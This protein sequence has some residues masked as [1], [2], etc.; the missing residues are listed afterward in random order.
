VAADFRALMIILDGLRSRSDEFHLIV[1]FLNF[2]VL[3]FKTC[4]HSF[5]YFLLLRDNCFLFC[6]GRL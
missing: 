3:F 6:N 4:R 5:I 1:H 2:C